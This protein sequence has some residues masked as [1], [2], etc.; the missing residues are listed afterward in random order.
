VV[1]T[2]ELTTALHTLGR[3]EGVT[4]FMTVLAAWA[5]LLGRRAGQDD[6]VVGAPVVVHRDRSELNDVIGLF[7]NSLPLRM[8]LSGAPAFREL[9]RRSRTTALE[10]FAHQEVPFEKVVEALALPRDTSRN[11][12][13]QAWFNHSAVPRE[14]LAFGG[15]GV[16]GVDVGEPAVKF[17]VRLSAEEYEGRM[18]LNLAYNADL[19]DRGT[20]LVLLDELRRLLEGAA[21]RPDAT[22][23]ELCGG[24]NAADPDSFRMH[25]KGIRRKAVTIE[26]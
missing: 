14:P 20:A 17:D 21:A 19:F 10:A 15:L 5:G 25:L 12:V 24:A 18:V 6:V 11:P 23:A 8:D 2:T 22:V 3:R 16:E 26:T 1:L 13:F 7:L 4:A 9:L